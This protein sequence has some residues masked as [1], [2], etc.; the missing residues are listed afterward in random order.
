MRTQHSPRGRSFHVAVRRDAVRAAWAHFDAQPHVRRRTELH[1]VETVDHIADIIPY[2]KL[3]S[4]G[5]SN[6]DHSSRRPA[7]RFMKR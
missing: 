4:L 3:V 6:Q 7:M 2:G 5:T 1:C